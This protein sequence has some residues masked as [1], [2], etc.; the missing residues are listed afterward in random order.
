VRAC[1]MCVVMSFLVCGWRLRC[2]DPLGAVHTTWTWFGGGVS[3]YGRRGPITLIQVPS[4]PI[5]L[6]VCPSSQTC[7]A[8]AWSFVPPRR[9][10]QQRHGRYIGQREVYGPRLGYPF[11]GYTI[12]SPSLRVTPWS[13][14]KAF[15]LGV[16]SP[17]CTQ[18]HQ[19]DVAPEPPSHT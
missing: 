17:E 5:C 11:P 14:S 8:G 10:V 2:R 19:Y 1:T 13:R 12:A 16:R 4:L 15:L 9:L 3:C 18:A 6:V 7:L